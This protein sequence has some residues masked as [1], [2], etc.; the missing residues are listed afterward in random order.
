[1]GIKVKPELDLPRMLAFKDEG[2]KG[3]VEGVAFLFKKNKIDP[4]HG[5]GRSPRRARSR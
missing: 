3:N 5:T 1:M 4:F 2:V